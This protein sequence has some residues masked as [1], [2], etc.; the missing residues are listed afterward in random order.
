[1][2]AQGLGTV[3]SSAAEESKPSTLS[4]AY[5]TN[6]HVPYGARDAQGWGNYWFC[7]GRLSPCRDSLRRE[8][9]PSGARASCHPVHE[10]SSRF[11]H[12]QAPSGQAEFPKRSRPG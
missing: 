1:M 12:C 11:P 5:L 4:T 6:Q 7:A 9:L 2:H 3:V 10:R 8:K